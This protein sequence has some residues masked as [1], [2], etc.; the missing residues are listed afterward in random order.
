MYS[1][2]VMAALT[3]GAEAPERSWHTPTGCYG[4]YGC[5]GY[6]GCYGGCQGY[7][8]PAYGS[9]TSGYW[10]GRHGHHS[11][12]TGFGGNGCAGAHWGA[13]SGTTYYG[14]NG[15][16][17]G[18]CF[19]GNGCAGSY[20]WGYQSHVVPSGNGG[21]S[22]Q[23]NEP[24]KK[25][26]PP[27]DGNGSSDDKKSSQAQSPTRARLI[28]NVPERAEVFI[29]GQRM[30]TKSRRRAFRTPELTPGQRYVYSV[31]AEVTR[32]GKKEVRVKRIF[33][34]P[35]EQVIA[36]FDDL[37]AAEPSVRTVSK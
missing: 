27:V 10:K 26:M 9:A 21:Q 20:S 29:E 4:C 37:H 25:K 18:A 30:K 17:Y 32:N 33:I 2:V 13:P 7:T 6:A 34:R 8:L 5:Y 28:V 35:G 11:Y 15:S 12:G 31:R 16:G 1:L 19:G 3:S 23:Q 36:T 22:T 24:P 14:C